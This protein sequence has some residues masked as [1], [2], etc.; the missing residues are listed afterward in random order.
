MISQRG[1]MDSQ[2][3]VLSLKTE[4]EG[5]IIDLTGKV[6]ETLRSSGMEE[7][8]ACVSVPH[9]TAAV[10]TIENEPGLQ[11]D[12]RAALES[13]APKNMDY[14]HQKTWGDGNGHSHIRAS[15][16]GSSV[17]VPFHEKKL[18]LGTW[19]QIVLMELDR[20]GRERKVIIQ[21]LGSQQ[22]T[23]SQS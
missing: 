22:Q 9:S 20:S 4:Q 7:G 8:L 5:D 13:I 12:I 1:S 11:K 6:S 16:L 14:E 17:T 2:R 23:R 21:L 19:Q 10:F 3:K 15:L 18:D